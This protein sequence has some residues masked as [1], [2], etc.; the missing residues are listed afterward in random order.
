LLHTVK[1][2]SLYL[3]QGKPWL[4]KSERKSRKRK[5]QA[6]LKKRRLFVRQFRRAPLTKN[7]L[8]ESEAFII[9]NIAKGINNLPVN[10]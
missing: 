1:E 4:I 5:K 2:L 8:L 9:K 6:L 3:T 10:L 7:T